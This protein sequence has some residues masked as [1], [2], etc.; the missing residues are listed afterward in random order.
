MGGNLAESIRAPSA[1]LNHFA[2]V[3]QR[4]VSQFKSRIALSL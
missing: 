2:E 3:G 1:L 4:I